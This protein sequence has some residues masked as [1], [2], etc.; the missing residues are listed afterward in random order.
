MKPPI[1]ID[2][3]RL[4]LRLPEIADAQAIFEQYAQDAEVTRYLTWQPHRAMEETTQF[5]KRLLASWREG[6]I[7][8]WVVTRKPDY[9]LLG[10]IAL[11]IEGH[12]ANLGYVL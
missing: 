4:R 2:T 12:K 1:L 5:L 3:P 8:S 9:Q 7:F 11:R 6:E 10:M